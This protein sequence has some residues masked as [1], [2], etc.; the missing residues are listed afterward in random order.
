MPYVSSG[1][2]RIHYGVSGAGSA[3]MLIAGTGYSGATWHPRLCAALA[4]RHTLITFDH[5]GT[6]R[7]SS[8]DDDYTT[9]MFG[10]DALAV[11]QAVDAGPA[12]VLG[13]SMGGRVATELYFAAPSAVQS[14]VFAASGAGRDEPEPVDRVGIPIKATRAMVTVGYEKY[15]RDKHRSNYFTRGFA[16][17]H[18]DEVEWLDRAFQGSA[19]FLDDYLKHV[20][21]RQAHGA[22]ARLSQVRVPSLVMVGSADTYLGGTG[23]HV[24][25]AHKLCQLLPQVRFELIDG[26]KHGFL[27]ENVDLSVELLRRFTDSFE[28][29]RPAPVR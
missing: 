15:I 13:H 1:N 3:F 26:A 12:H 21:A 20:R 25:G 28:P 16:E 27:W 2:A 5:R 6:G 10:T 24:E 17:E 29:L 19:P 8:T 11:L 22:A 14:L 4:Q 9:A 18:P 23:S 7:S